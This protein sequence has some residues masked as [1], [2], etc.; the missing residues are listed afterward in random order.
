LPRLII[1]LSI[2]QVG[3]ETAHLL[4]QNFQFSIFNFQK[5]TREELEKIEGVGPIVARSITDWF[6]DKENQKLL[7]RLLKQV[8]IQKS[9]SKLLAP[10]SKLSG[11]TFVLTGTLVNMSRDEAKQKIRERGGSVSS[12]VSKE[13]DFVVAGEN[14]G[15][16]YDRAKNLGVKILS[17]SEF[18]KMVKSG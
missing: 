7:S 9:F 15:S 8:K 13:T 4:A 11:K 12:S 18:E 6:K 17:Q 10:S 5:A 14:P 3:E 1:G 16:K 2:P